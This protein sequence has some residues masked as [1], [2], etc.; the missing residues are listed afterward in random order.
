M[1]IKNFSTKKYFI[2]RK[3]LKVVLLLVVLRI[4]E[5]QQQQKIYKMKF[6]FYHNVFA[7]NDTQI[8]RSNFQNK[9][10]SSTISFEIPLNFKIPFL[11][12]GFYGF[13]SYQYNAKNKWHKK[14]QFGVL[15]S[16]TNVT[17][18]TNLVFYTCMLCRYNLK[19]FM[20][21]GN[22]TCTKRRTKEF[23][24]ITVCVSNFLQLYFTV[25]CID[26]KEIN[27]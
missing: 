24:Y 17:E 23:Q 3:F 8:C 16:K 7:V 21:I 20:N 13:L 10:F 26:H 14:F 27:V 15:D 9:R 11:V 1:L 6:F 22:I 4:N 2:N 19:L 5:T 18:T 25:D 12:V